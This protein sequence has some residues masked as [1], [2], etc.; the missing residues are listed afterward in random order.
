LWDV[1]G[2]CERAGS[3]DSNIRNATPNDFGACLTRHRRVSVIALNGRK[4]ADVFRRMALPRLPESITD[5]LTVLELPSTSPANA[6]GGFEALFAEWR[7]LS[8]WV[9][10]SAVR[11]T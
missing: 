4:A 9:D 5:R 8:E 6:R 2:A 3:L 10:A 7:A 1:I 11:A